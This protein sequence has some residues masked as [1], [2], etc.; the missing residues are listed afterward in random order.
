MSDSNSSFCIYNCLTGDHAIVSN[1]PF[2][3]G[4][5]RDADLRLDDPEVAPDHCFIHQSAGKYF[6]SPG[7]G[8]DG[9]L[10]DGVFSPG[11]ALQPQQDYTLC[12]GGN[13]LAIRG[14]AQP[15]K[16]LRTLNAAE[17]LI[18]NSIT[19]IRS[20]P[21]PPSKLLFYL[22]PVDGSL[23]HL[24]L[25]C[26]G[27]TSMGF[28]A[29]SIA[30]YLEM[31]Y[32]SPPPLP[33]SSNGENRREDV[34]PGPEEPLNSTVNIEHGTFPDPVCCLKFDR[35]DIMHI[36]SHGSLR[37]DPILGEEHMQRFLATRFNDRGQGLDAMNRS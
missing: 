4:S 19:K 37:G 27:L 7:Q 24:V 23:K 10:M 32:G 3:I 21:I 16:W 13:F 17:W 15:K 1:S 30:P 8:V 14:E 34:P 28:T 25:F 29:E 9:L 22:E 26:R 12:I 2:K 20:G 33:V 35:G 31:K 11:E 6:L 18:Y 5:A 36:A